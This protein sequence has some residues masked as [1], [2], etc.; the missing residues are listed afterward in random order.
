V[1][2]QVDIAI[3]G[4]G[5]SGIGAAVHLQR[6][7]P[8]KS[9]AILEGRERMGGTWDLFRYPGIRS[10]SDMYT[11]GYS[12]KPWTNPVAIADGA[13]IL[14]YVKDTAAEYGIDSKIRYG[15]RVTTAR[16]HHDHWTLEPSGLTCKFLY[17]CTGYYNV[18]RGYTPVF[19]GRERFR[20]HIVHP[21]QWP[22]ELAYAGKRVIVIGSGATAVTLVPAMAAD[23]AHVTMLQRSPTYVISLPAR[24]PIANWLRGK[25]S[26]ERAYTATRWKNVALTMSFYALCR[27]YP[28]QAKKLLLQRVAKMA[29]DQIEHFTPR[30]NPWEQRLCVVPD[31]DLFRAIESRRASVVTDTIDTFTETGIQL[32]SGKHLDADIIVTATGLDLQ[33]FGGM[34]IEVDGTMIDAPKTTVYKGMMLSGV[35]NLAFAMG[36]TNASWTLKADLTCQH[37]CRLLGYMDKNGYKRVVPRRPANLGEV[38]IIDFSSGY[39]QRAL[40]RMPQQG[41]IRPWRLYQN[42]AL[43]TY[44]LVHARVNDPALELT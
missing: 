16:W 23:A 26:A 2:T 39:I 5:L 36:Y 34:Q 38:P 17:M 7:H 24:D 1:S 33:W 28:Q 3:V 22:A 29:P 32:T 4:A 11:L 35:P 18:E 21:Q 42:Y 6:A 12:F 31:A 43:D 41:V 15:Q 27:R 20:G 44:E 30:Y 8:G 25:M 40:G 19:P 13:S 10:D 9:I 37:V 14:K